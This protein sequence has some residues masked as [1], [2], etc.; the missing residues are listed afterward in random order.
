MPKKPQKIIF[1]HNMFWTCIF[2][3]RFCKSTNN[4]LSYCGLT[5]SK[6]GA[7]DTDLPVAHIFLFRSIRRPGLTLPVVMVCYMTRNFSRAVIWITTK[8]TTW[9][10]VVTATLLLPS[11]SYWWKNKLRF[12]FSKKK[13]ETKKRKN[14][15]SIFF[16]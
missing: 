3:I 7:S 10:L 2:L 12:P 1:V 16:Y 5:D 8:F 13:K 6:L 14:L 11:C 9:L 15:T 4:L